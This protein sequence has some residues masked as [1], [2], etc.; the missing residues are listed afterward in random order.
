MANIKRNHLTNCALSRIN[1]ISDVATIKQKM[2]TRCI[3]LVQSG[4]GFLHNYRN[5]VYAEINQT[6]IA[7]LYE[8]LQCN[9]IFTFQ[10]QVTDLVSLDKTMVI[11]A[12]GNILSSINVEYTTH[13]ITNNNTMEYYLLL[14]VNDK[15]MFITRYG[16][17]F[18]LTNMIKSF[19]YELNHIK[20]EKVD[21]DKFKKDSVIKNFFSDFHDLILSYNLQF[22]PDIKIELQTYL[23]RQQNEIDHLP[24]VTFNRFSQLII[25]GIISAKRYN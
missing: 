8:L 16:L 19:G 18:G 1:D 13:S 20:M 23:E 21:H 15:K 5:D 2:N 17:F 9:K 7:W 22:E 24:A 25:N 12:L 6:N 11:E 4:F 14:K 3:F 10:R